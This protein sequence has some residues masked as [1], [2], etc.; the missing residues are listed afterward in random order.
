MRTMLPEWK[1]WLLDHPERLAPRGYQFYVV[2]SLCRVL[3][4]LQHGAIAS[5]PVAARWTQGTLRLHWVPLIE[6]ALEGRHI[7]D[8]LAL[9]ADINQTLTLVRQTL[10][11]GAEAQ[12]GQGEGRGK[13]QDSQQQRFDA[14][15]VL[16][17][18][19]AHA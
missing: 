18:H 17:R 2:L 10:A 16:T 14:P 5:K 7:P 11:V 12:T 8:T 15:D 1:E 9:P 6:R 4:T 13:F 3:Y 19:I